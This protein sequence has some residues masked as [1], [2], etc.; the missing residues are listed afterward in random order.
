MKRLASDTRQKGRHDLRAWLFAT[1]VMFWGLAGPAQAANETAAKAAVPAKEAAAEAVAP[2]AAALLFLIDNSLS[3]RA[4]DP[5]ALSIGAAQSF[6]TQ[7]PFSKARIAAA[8]FA[9][10]AELEVPFRLDGEERRLKPAI[11]KALAK[12]DRSGTSTDL[13]AALRAGLGFLKEEEGNPTRALVLFTDGRT[14]E[15]DRDESA[16][17]K[18]RQSQERLLLDVLPLY[19]QA[20][21]PIY[22]LAFGKDPDLPL[23]QEIA[24][25]TG[26]RAFKIE[27]AQDLPAVYFELMAPR[28][29]TRFESLEGAQFE[30]DDSVREATLIFS[31]LNHPENLTLLDPQEKRQSAKT[32]DPG[33]V[34][35]GGPGR[36]SISLK[37]PKPGR[38]RVEGA[39][40]GKGR[41]SFL[42]DLRLAARLGAETI[43]ADEPIYVVARLLSNTPEGAET[44]GT[45]QYQATLF[46]AEGQTLGVVPLNSDGSST[47]Q[48]LL[49]TA[50]RHKD[51]WA[52]GAFK[53]REPLAPGAYTVRVSAKTAALKRSLTLPLRVVEG[54]WVRFVQ[55]ETTIA[56]A[57]PLLFEFD[58][59]PEV[60]ERLRPSREDEPPVGLDAAK[61]F[62]VYVETPDGRALQAPLRPGK[63]RRYQ[64]ALADPPAGAYTLRVQM[65]A[66]AVS[67][68][69]FPLGASFG[70]KAEVPGQGDKE[71]RG[72]WGFTPGEWILGGV[73]LVL[74]AFVG[75]LW[76]KTQR[77][78]A[79]LDSGE[80]N[81]LDAVTVIRTPDKI[82]ASSAKKAP[83][84]AAET[85]QKP[86]KAVPISK[87]EV[88]GKLEQLISEAQ[89]E[90]TAVAAPKPEAALPEE[91]K[92]EEPAEEEDDVVLTSDALEGKPAAAKPAE[93]PATS[94]EDELQ[95]ALAGLKSLD[96][97]KAQEEP[98]PEAPKEPVEAPKA[99]KA[100]DSLAAAGI[101]LGAL[102]AMLAENAGK[103]QA[104]KAEPEPEPEEERG[105]S[106]MDAEGIARLLEENERHPQEAFE[107]PSTSQD[108]Q[109]AI[110]ADFVPATVL[111]TY[112][113]M[114]INHELGWTRDE[115]LASPPPSAPPEEVPAA[116]EDAPTSPAQSDAD[117]F[118][119]EAPLAA[120]TAEEYDAEPINR[121]LGWSADELAAP[122]PPTTFP[123]DDGPSTML[124]GADAPDSEPVV[125]YD[126]DAINGE[127]GWK[128]EE[129]AAL[130]EKAQER[131]PDEAPPA[132]PLATP[133]AATES[134][135]ADPPPA[136]VEAPEASPP[137]EEETAAPAAA[138]PAQ[139]LDAIND[140]ISQ[141]LT[142]RLG[143]DTAVADAAPRP[144]LESAAPEPS[145]VLAATEEKPATVTAE[146]S[147]GKESEE[148]DEEID[149]PS[150]APAT[151][152]HETT[153]A[154][155]AAKPQP[156]AQSEGEKLYRVR[157]AAKEEPFDLDALLQMVADETAK[158][159]SKPES[160]PEPAPSA[161]SFNL[162]EVQKLLRENGYEKP[163]AET[164]SGSFTALPGAAKVQAAHDESGEPPSATPED[165][166]TPREP[167][168]PETLDATIARLEEMAK[169]AGGGIKRAKTN[170]GKTV[171]KEGWDGGKGGSGA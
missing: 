26:G 150:S 124:S 157:K 141:E 56:K 40:A 161:S 8:S 74:L 84:K 91:R 49:N 43:V 37:D 114:A 17:A 64:A 96:F 20:E 53:P 171:V 147:D 86:Q 103:A 61:P 104:Q 149:L 51:G 132:E 123:H 5:D 146:A 169:Q 11:T 36:L 71:S 122:L 116:V 98:K 144:P 12:L 28:H 128:A 134:L 79:E 138:Q 32:H 167:G 54:N 3:M 133:A 73:I 75:L 18:P 60:L 148:G 170:F 55:P 29:K 137:V 58:F 89:E 45:A 87:E 77:P 165:A 50:A 127:L 69:C 33:I 41:L 30:I 94:A 57:A 52:A 78:L 44:L 97:S 105:V 119:E 131:A 168:E 140:L 112:D 93:K 107:M 143:N 142:K 126:T 106:A 34:W 100:K 72:L 4:A 158:R 25:K 65:N 120:Q 27:S 59:A 153:E 24:K 19:R 113:D 63:G 35:S 111:E 7:T 88:V 47:G 9:Y 102:S 135:P 81:E 90:P 10:G 163:K 130:A 15:N 159:E 2:E 136:A 162:D 145:A 16:Q 6:I 42:A 101:D 1:L 66:A 62:I 139:D 99:E 154:P 95:K 83:D 117:A 76:R 160:K 13:E 23:L 121:L 108:E 21:I 110:T 156:A 82:P 14:S 125:L 38:W 80:L 92:P 118:M 46:D 68:L 70:F 67:P 166:E 109:M 48:C 152:A 164:A 115:L 155:L 129:L 22:T 31:E 85:P 39:E 151:P